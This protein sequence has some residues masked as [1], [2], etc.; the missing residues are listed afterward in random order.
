MKETR[1]EQIKQFIENHIPKMDSP[2]K[3]YQLLKGLGYKTLD[4]KFK[5][6]EVFELRD[7]DRE[8]VKKIYTIANYE[9][10]FQIFLV[11]LKTFSATIT[12]NLSSYFE[13]K[14]QYPFLIFTADY[15]NYTFVLIKKIREDVG[16]WKR[17]LIK[18][19]LDRENTFYTDKW[20]LSEIALKDGIDDPLKIYALF[21]ESF[22][23]QK[24]TKKF[25]IE[26][27]Q[28]FDFLAESLKKNN[29]GVASF[30]D[31]KKL[32][33]FAQKF[34]GRLMFLYFLQKKGWLA[35]DKK[36]IDKWFEKAKIRGNTFYHSVLEPLF[37]EILNKKRENDESLFGKIPFLNGGLF[38]KD[39]KDFIHIPNFTI[40]TILKFL[41]SYNFTISEELPLEVEV[42]VNPEMLGRIFESML[43]E[44]ERGEKGTFYTPRSIVHYMCRESLKEYLSSSTSVPRYKILKLI[45]KKKTKELSFSETKSLYNAL[46]TVK[47]LDP[48]VGSGAFLVGMMREIIRLRKPLGEKLGIKLTSAQ[49]KREIIKSNL[50]GID[51]ETE[52]IEI[53]KLRLW[54]SL[55]VD[56]ELKNI[57][58]L[59]NLDCKLAVGNSLI[60]SLQGKKLLKKEGYQQFFTEDESMGLIRESKN[61]KDRYAGETNSDEESNLY[62]RIENIE[63]GLIKKGLSQETE[64]KTKQAIGIGAKYSRAG[65]QIPAS[66]KKRMNKLV[67]EATKANNFF[68]EIKRTGTKPFFLP[69]IHF[70]EVFVEKGGF[71]IVIANPPYVRTQ[72][73]SDLFYRDDLRLHYGYI[74]DLY[75]HFTFRAFELTRPKGIVTF[76]TSDTYLTLTMKERMRKLLQSNRIQRLILT[77]KAFEATV[78]TA[79]YIAQKDYL[80]DYNFTFVDAREIAEDKNE[81]WED[82]LLVF[83]ELKEIESYDT[84]IPVQLE[85]SK[86]GKREIEV[87]YNRYADV[88]QYRVPV[89]LYK[90][91]VKDVFFSPTR[92]NLKVYKKFMPKISE[93]YEKWWDKIKTSK[94]I[95]KNKGKIE[96]HLKTLKPGDMTLLGLAT[97]GGQGLATADNGRF[98]AILEETDGARK[99][100]KRLEELERKWKKRNPDIYETYRKLLFSSELFSSKGTILDNLRKRFEARLGLPRGF[101]Y[102]IIKK[103]DVFDVASYLE[104][105]DPGIREIMR[106]IIIFAGIPES[107]TDVKN[108][109]KL[110]KLPLD[111]KKLDRDLKDGIENEY[112]KL[113]TVGKWIAFTRGGEA[114]HVFWSS[115]DRFIDWSRNS[116]RELS[117]SPKARWQGYEHFL[118]E[119]ITYIDVGGSTIKARVL[120]ASIYDH[121]A[122]SF[123]PD[124][125]DISPKYLLGILNTDFASYFANE[126]LNHTM[127]FELNDIRLF[128]IVIPTES[129]REEIQILVDQAIQIQ[130]MRY[131]TRDKEEKTNLWENLQRVQKEIDNK[132][133]EIYGIK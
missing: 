92:R 13:K 102:K 130:K 77:P 123:F 21:N 49:L 36:F 33:T 10:R 133:E 54:L 104:S 110:P 78:N 88:E 93:L 17:K 94:E 1:M 50:Y 44:H 76:I 22:Q 2:E 107:E 23:V 8:A 48:A 18:L 128:P 82:K 97:E 119:G 15:Q 74:D 69:Q 55:V 114:E 67:E 29:K 62:K 115:S 58:P 126:Y 81:N 111:L 30:Y 4:P 43:P 113:K 84:Q 125:K 7:K 87:S 72:K 65:L 25:F 86:T 103:E 57:E 91:A 52:A 39:Y 118:Q 124:E 73:L 131:T 37:F 56:E 89:S 117:T 109:W 51:I 34:L 121:T 101:I 5:A 70:I 63:W 47:I 11:E 105:L 14:T 95:Q 27:K 20:I 132:V 68:E 42:A 79:I 53:A 96:G 106:Q 108:L 26:Y 90:N 38:E 120:P 64:L 71:D 12:R 129:Q 41:N 100:E 24:V 75:V 31:K 28:C 99:I 19:N 122:H 85:N 127:H 59:P 6:K 3:V 40:E 83:E 98:L 116:V 9:G 61:L 35:N 46:K 66:E 45:E 80:E 112:R 60:E 16:V 32:Y